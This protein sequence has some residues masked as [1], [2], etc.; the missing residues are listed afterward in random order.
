MAVM[1][2]NRHTGDAAEFSKGF[3]LTRRE[4]G[5]LL[6]MAAGSALV[7]CGGR[8]EYVQMQRRILGKTGLSVSVVGFGTEWMERHTQSECDAVMRRCEAYGMNLLDCWSADP[9]LRDRIGRSL[10]GHRENGLFRDTLVRLGKME[11]TSAR[12]MSTHAALRLMTCCTDSARTQLRS[13]WFT[14]SIGRM[15]TPISSPNLFS[16]FSGSSSLR[17]RSSSWA[18]RPTTR[19]PPWL[20]RKAVSLT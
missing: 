7:G 15:N 1:E 5:A 16:H 19:R 12:V 9:T 8:K 3:A 18:C 2:E 4:V 6:A 13:E 20:R 10:K 11:N 14:A 17:E